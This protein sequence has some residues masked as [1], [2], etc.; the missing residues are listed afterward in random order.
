[1]VPPI[2]WET[3]AEGGKRAPVGT[4]GSVALFGMDMLTE[5]ARVRKLTGIDVE[6]RIGI[7][8]G[9]C[10][11]GIVGKSRPRYFIW[12]H[13]TV[14]ANRLESTGRPGQ[15]Q[16]SEA[17]SQRLHVEGFLLEPHQTVSH[18]ANGGEPGPYTDDSV[19]LAANVTRTYLLRGW[20]SADGLSELHVPPT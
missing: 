5:I 10:I 8:T 13:D 18:A 20:R 9:R 15:I 12:G 6:L 3:P 19:P 17:T 2:D 11:G 1:M 7:H 14:L 4:C 16:V